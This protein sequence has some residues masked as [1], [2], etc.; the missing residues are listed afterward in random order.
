MTYFMFDNERSKRLIAAF[1]GLLTIFPHQKKYLNLP[2]LI[3]SLR[4]VVRSFPHYFI[5]IDQ[6]SGYV[7][8]CL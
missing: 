2:D 3:F 8:H 4:E 6:E 1:Y 7:I 5:Y